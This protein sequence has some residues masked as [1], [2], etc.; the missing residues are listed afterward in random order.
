[1]AQ[2]VD[3][4]VP[5]K[6]AGVAQLVEHHLAKVDVASSSLVTRS[7]LRLER[8]A[9]RGLE[10]ARH[11]LGKGGP[12]KRSKLQLAASLV[13]YC[14]YLFKSRSRPTQPYIGST[15][16]LRQRVKQHNEGRSPHT[17]KFRP[18]TL[19]AYFAFADKKTAV[20]FERY[21]KSGS[22]RSFV[23]RHFL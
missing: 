8:S 15:C 22:G 6:T 16:D 21:L 4:I 2:L 10:R 20:A 19:L 5:L 17:A 12:P 23:N 9:N 3:I 1:V 13:M 7:S 11:S 18:W 14:V